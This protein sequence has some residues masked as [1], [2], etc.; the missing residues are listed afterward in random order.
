MVGTSL[1]GDQGLH[2]FEFV[3]IHEIMERMMLRTIN[4]PFA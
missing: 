1:S 4:I 3:S 2:V